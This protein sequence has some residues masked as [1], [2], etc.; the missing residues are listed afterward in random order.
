VSLVRE[1]IVL[2]KFIEDSDPIHDMGIGINTLRNF[3]RSDEIVDFYIKILPY[4]LHTNE[5]PEDILKDSSHILNIYYID[6]YLNPYNEKYIRLNGRMN[7]S[8]RY[9]VYI[10]LRNR[11]QEMGFKRK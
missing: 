4:I 3:H 5:I 6:T 1:H 9:D 2:E 11:L 7:V 8:I 10:A